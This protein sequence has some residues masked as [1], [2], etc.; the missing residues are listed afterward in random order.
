MPMLTEDQEAQA[1]DL[2]K[3]TAGN[4]ETQ[5]CYWPPLRGQVLFHPALAQSWVVRCQWKGCPC[6]R[7]FPLGMTV[8][9]GWRP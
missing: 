4:I 6:F 3:A 1:W 5:I 9:P 8:N 2:P 7:P